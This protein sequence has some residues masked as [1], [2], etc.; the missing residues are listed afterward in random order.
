MSLDKH[1]IKL[2][3][4]NTTVTMGLLVTLVGLLW[5][6]AIVHQCLGLFVHKCV[7]VGVDYG[8]RLIGLA[9]SDYFGKV[10]P[11]ATIRNTGNL[12]KISEDIAKFAMSLRA[13]EVILGIPLDGSSDGQVS[14]RVKNMNGKICLNFSFV[15][16]CIVKSLCPD[17]VKVRLC[18]ESYSTQE[19]KVKQAFGEEKGAV[20]PFLSVHVG[21]MV[22]ICLSIFQ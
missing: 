22:I 1:S 7:R 16:T 10:Y 18:D 20:Y 14:R 17:I 21:N 9:Y 6:A 3:L 2:A 12:T 19:A 5:G 8:P 13:R 15:L 4:L 11:H